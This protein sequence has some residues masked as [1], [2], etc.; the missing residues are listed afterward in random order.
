MSFRSALL[1]LLLLPCASLAVIAAEP[2]AVEL[3]AKENFQLFLLVGQS[4]MAGRG[5]VAP[6][7]KEANP[8][9]L[10]LNK[11]GEWVP[12]VDPIHF[13]KSIA[14]VGLGRTFGLEIAKANPDVTIGLIPCAVGGTPI[15]HWVPGAYDPPTKTHP[16]DDMLPR[17]KKALESGTLCGI[18]WH[19]GEGDA[20]PTRSKAYEKNLTELVDRLRK[21]LDVP[22]APF[23]LGQ[24]GQFE[25]RPW[26]ESTHAVDKAQRHYAETHD[27][28]LFVSSDGLNHKGDNVHFDAASYRELG[29]R[30]AKAY[31]EMPQP[32]SASK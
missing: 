32:K 13:D 18:L 11:Q 29:K 8:R 17:A 15:E 25:G 24:L 31:L 7:D 2:D 26:T 28:A 21:E 4:N 14:G 22:D 9:V 6:Q 20:N 16:Y 27:N 1:S 23:I 5:K 19:Q 12:A 30:Y 3:P 10:T